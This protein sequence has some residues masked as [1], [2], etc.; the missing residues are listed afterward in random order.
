[1]TTKHLANAGQDRNFALEEQLA[2]ALRTGQRGLLRAF[3][4][5]ASTMDEAHALAAG[6]AGEGSLVVALR[7]SQGR[8]RQGRA[9][10]SPE[11]GVYLS[12]VFRPKRPVDEVPQLALVA[13]LALAEA[14]K[15]TTGLIGS[16]RWPNDLLLGEQKLAGVLV[17][18]RA[19]AAV[20]GVGVNI[21]TDPN[22]LPD[23]GTSLAAAGHVCA[24]P[25]LTATLYTRLLAWYD[26][27]S[28][29][30]FPPVRQ[31]LRPWIGLFGQVVHIS[32]GSDRFE[33]TA[34]D[35]DER[36]RLVVR[37][38]AGTLRPFDMGEVTLLR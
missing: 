13:G 21:D 22:E 24:V 20:V 7:Q 16:I 17:E 2:D 5:V 35:L 30:G 36:G 6:G 28:A 26:V 4:S 14:V 31:A 15:T 19:G 11:G 18:A 3:Q 25:K 8:G 33:G 10:E 37:L 9:W 32:A 12:V 38:D 23:T 1:M 34:Q 27:W 29:K